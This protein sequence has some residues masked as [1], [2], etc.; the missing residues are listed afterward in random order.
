MSKENPKKMFING[1][2]VLASDNKTYDLFNP[3]SGELI[4]KICDG[5]QV[6]T[7]KAIYADGKNMA[8]GKL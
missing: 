5:G 2:F 7:A 1:E 6:E 8:G 4:A 3:S